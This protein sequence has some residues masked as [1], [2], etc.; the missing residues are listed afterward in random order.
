M[1]AMKKLGCN[2]VRIHIAG[3][4]PRIYNLADKIGLLLWVEV[5][6]PHTSTTLSR[7]YHREEL[8]RML[9]L[10]ETHPSVVIWSLYNE[11]WGAQDIAT[12]PE[13]RQYIIDMYHYMQIAHPQFLVVD[14][15]GWQ[16]IS[17][18][19]KLKSDLLTAHLYT[20]ELERWKQML[21]QIV[22]G[23]MEGVAAY[24]LV[25]GDPFFF[26]KQVPLIISEWG[27]FGFSDY[28]GPKGSDERT[29]LIK[30]FKDELRRRPIAGDVYTQATNIED[31]RNGLIHP[32]TGAL[33]VPE[34]LLNSRE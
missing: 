10:I 8:L 11:D 13:T 5:P 4:D 18:T 26:R 23:K 31:E 6:S 21:D 12:N 7:K 29:S 20:P 22:G 14:N 3:V 2:L 25:V 9:A 28:G 17:Y 15:D 34:G 24:P 33:E 19:G 1:H 27:G 16:H 32:H 30:A